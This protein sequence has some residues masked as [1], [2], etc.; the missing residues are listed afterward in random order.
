[1]SAG[2]SSD[3]AKNIPATVTISIQ[4]ED[5]KGDKTE[6]C[7]SKQFPPDATIAD[8]RRWVAGVVG[9][10]FKIQTLPERK[11]LPTDDHMSL[12]E[13]GFAPS[14]AFVVEPCVYKD[15]DDRQELIP[16][17]EVVVIGPFRFI[18]PYYFTF[19][20][21]AKGRWFGRKLVDVFC[22]EFK[23]WSRDVIEQRIRD[24]DITV[25][26]ETIPVDYE[27]QEH[28]KIKHTIT[29]TESPVYNRPILKIGETDDYLAFLKPA[30]IPVHATG[31]YLYNA[32]VK[33]IGRRY[34]PVHR[35]DRV[36]S[37]IIVM[38]K[39]KEAA[40][41]FG[42]MLQDGKISKTYLARVRGV[43]PEGE[44]RCDAPI[45]EKEKTREIRECG[46]GGKESLTLFKR[47]STNGTESIVECHPITGRTHQIRVHLAHLGYPI[48]NDPLYGG[49]KIGLSEEEE[50]AIA[51]AEKQGLW[52]PDTIIG[53]DDAFNVFQIYL[54]SF[55]YQSSVFDFNAPLPE[56]ADLDNYP[57][58]KKSWPFS[59][60]N[61]C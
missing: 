60:C 8:V 39:N 21:T 41:N 29:R 9:V 17:C 33:Q 4:E 28:D 23:H 6:R 14:A 55:H 26:D 35:L 25:N 43:F 50:K 54:H 40:Q 44:I 45:R 59:G 38:A 51:M 37:G 3:E 7:M 58:K 2:S 30:S 49:E 20:C 13:A 56:W 61:V 16:P 12:S 27:I 1:M 53:K 15:E 11:S 48:S 34:H 31:G 5:A 42:Q 52:P 36:T 10:G 57:P 22:Q 24:G 19:P 32:M 18:R 46:E 47:V